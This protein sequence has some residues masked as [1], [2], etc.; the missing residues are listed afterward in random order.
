MIKLCTNSVAH[1][2][3]LVF[4]LTLWLLVHLLAN[5]KEQIMFQ[6][7]RRMI[8]K[9]YK[10]ID[11]Y[12][13]YTYTVKVLKSLFLM[14]FSHFLRT[15]ICYLNINRFFAQVIHVFINH[16]QSL[17]TY[18]Q[19]LSAIQLQRFAVCSLTYL[20]LLIEFVTMDYY[21]N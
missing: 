14:N 9:Q 6:F 4:P 12:L 21:L 3:A 7:I 1:P 2:L 13:F 8:N 17:L 19:V 5:G 20:M 18:F 16:L 15:K 10:T 11:Q